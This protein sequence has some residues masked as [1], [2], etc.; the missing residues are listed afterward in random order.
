MRIIHHKNP[1]FECALPSV[2][3]Y[4][5]LTQSTHLHHRQDYRPFKSKHPH[6]FQAALLLEKRSQV[7]SN[8]ELDSHV[9][10]P[11]P[12]TRALAHLRLINSAACPGHAAQACA[13]SEGK[14]P[15]LS[16]VVESFEIILLSQNARRTN[17]VDEKAS[18]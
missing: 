18:G 3:N 5:C 12:R 13:R 6:N 9:Q 10:R 17:G 4:D 11:F 8:T 14:N 1:V 16:R 2:V 7:C 15:D